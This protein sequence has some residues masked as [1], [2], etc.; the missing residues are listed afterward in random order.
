MKEPVR[1][2][3]QGTK[4][5]GWNGRLRRMIW[6]AVVLLGLFFYLRFPVNSKSECLTID[7]YRCFPSI[8]RLWGQYSPYF[9]VREGDIKEQPGQLLLSPSI[10]EGCQVTMVNILSRHG[11]RYPTQHKSEIYAKLVHDIQRNVSAGSLRGRYA[12][13]AGYEYTLGADDLTALGERQMVD[14][15]TKFYKRYAS[16]AR[17]AVPFI[18]AS[19]SERVLVSGERFIDGFQQAKEDDR[20]ANHSQT[21]P[22][23]NVILGEGEGFNNSLDHGACG[24]FE[25]S[26]RGEAVQTNFTRLFAPSIRRRLQRDLAGVKLELDEVVYLMDLCAFDTVARTSDGSLLSPFCS[27]FTPDEWVEYD[28]LQSLG[29]Y[30]GYGAGNRLGIAQ[31]IGFTNELIARL[32]QSPVRDE[33]STNHT[34]DRDERTF[35]L[36]AAIYADFTHDNGL[37]PIFFALGLYNGTPPLDPRHVQDVKSLHGFSAAWTVPFAARAYVEKMLCPGHDDYLVRVLVN[38]RVVPLHGCSD[39]LGRCPLDAFVGG[40]HFNDVWKECLI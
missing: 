33:T 13:L 20:A 32:T 7:G 14:S 36:S 12:F 9:A 28:Y 4:S 37:V 29:K 26:T 40:L 35:P 1:V 24:R 3:W 34:L 16:L 22:F 15:G 25:A 30:Y 19:G 2:A 11:A 10:P 27:L 18:R 6:A 8:S 38:D 31:G 39:S 5:A 17:D 21:K 23:I